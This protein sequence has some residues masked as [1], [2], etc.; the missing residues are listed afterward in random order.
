MVSDEV[1]IT[2]KVAF[3]DRRVGTDVVDSDVGE[4]AEGEHGE[5]DP[6]LVEPQVVPHQVVAQP[7]SDLV[8]V[9]SAHRERPEIIFIVTHEQFTEAGSFVFGTVPT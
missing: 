4:F 3:G 5:S 1:P 7:L 2:E 6:R 8:E 9:F